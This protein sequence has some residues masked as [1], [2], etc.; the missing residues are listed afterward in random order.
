MTVAHPQIMPVADI[1]GDYK[2][3]S[4]HMCQKM[5]FTKAI[6]IFL[7][8]AQFDELEKFDDK[9]VDPRG[10]WTHAQMDVIKCDHTINGT[11]D[12]DLQL[13]LKPSSLFSPIDNW[14]LLCE[15]LT[16]YLDRPIVFSYFEDI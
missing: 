4:D 15:P 6:N 3:L 1:S 14:M 5:G 13:K 9:L 11:L 16:G 7:G 2:C 12:V 10:K 8:T